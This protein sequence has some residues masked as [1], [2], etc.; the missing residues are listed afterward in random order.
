MSF[1]WRLFLISTFAVL[2]PLAVLALGVRREMDRRLGDESRRRGSA[3]VTRLGA[4]LGRERER[5]VARLDALS[6]D[7]AGD[8]RFRLGLLGESALPRVRARLGRRRDAALR[9]LAPPSAGQ[10]R[11]DRELGP[12]PQRVRRG[13]PRG[14]AIPRG[15]RDLARAGAGPHRRSAAPRARGGRVGERGGETAHAGRRHRGGGALPPRPRPRP[16][17][18]GGAGRGP[19]GPARR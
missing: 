10:R 12:L 19:Y 13:A 15:G 16:G 18:D 9:A 11:S 7:L 3:A 5:V 8:N 2:V 17:P 6:R 14:P 1:R 4:E